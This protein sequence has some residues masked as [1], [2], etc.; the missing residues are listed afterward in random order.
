M[1]TDCKNRIQ[2]TLLIKEII[3]QAKGYCFIHL[4]ETIKQ[5]SSDHE[6]L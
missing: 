3:D 2:F 1:L 5:D 6:H 4:Y